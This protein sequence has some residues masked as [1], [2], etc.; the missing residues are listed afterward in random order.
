MTS[1][2]EAKAAATAIAANPAGYNEKSL[3]VAR[4]LLALTSGTDEEMALIIVTAGNDE[5][6]R[7]DREN[8]ER[9][10]KGEPVVQQGSLPEVI[11]KHVSAFAAAVRA[12]EREACA[13]I[14]EGL[15]I[16]Q[17]G[18]MFIASHDTKDRHGHAIATAIRERGNG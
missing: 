15:L 7:V 13:Q 17:E 16:A 1:I 6:S 11:A 5:Y 12:E 3:A 18:G 9:F 4:A 2:T 8:E 10:H 14:A